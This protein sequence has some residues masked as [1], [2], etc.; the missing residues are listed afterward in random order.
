MPAAKGAVPWNAGKG[1]G[2]TDKRG[3]RWIY[4]LEN[5]RRRAKREHREVMEQ[6]L[7]RQLEPEEVVHHKNGQTDDNRIENLELTTWDAHTRTHHNGRRRP[8]QERISLGVL[9]TY[10]EE[11]KRL[12]EI[13]ADLL[14]ELMSVRN[15][16]AEIHGCECDG[17]GD[18]ALCSVTAAIA[19]AEGRDA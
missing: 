18:C 12:K 15:W 17:E 19:K 14:A 10:R 16:I 13:N 9:A 2:W 8:D 3:Y 4:V 5:G 11:H 1:E 7:G 6:H